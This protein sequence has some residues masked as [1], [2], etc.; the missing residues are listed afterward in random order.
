VFPSPSPPLSLL[1]LL[2]ALDASGGRLIAFQF[3]LYAP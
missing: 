2:A 1:S 3:R